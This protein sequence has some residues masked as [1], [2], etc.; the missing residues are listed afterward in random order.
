MPSPFSQ[1]LPILNKMC[2]YYC[3][4]ESSAY[5]M[6]ILLLQ[7]CMC[8]H[9]CCLQSHKNMRHHCCSLTSYP[10]TILCAIIAVLSKVTYTTRYLPSLPFCQKLTKQRCICHHHRSVKSYL[11]NTVTVKTLNMQS[12]LLS[13]SYTCN[14]L[15][16][17]I[18]VISKSHETL[19][20]PPLLF[21]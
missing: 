15:C 7:H 1:K 2:N 20:V 16:T 13:G 3:M 18:A 21:P 17:I 5:N 9:H 11:Y 14:A 4:Q 12:A 6:Q 8:N 19:Y 10:Y